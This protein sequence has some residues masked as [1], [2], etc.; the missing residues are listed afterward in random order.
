MNPDE[1]KIQDRDA[2]QAA[3][4]VA[5]KLARIRDELANE[6]A[7][8]RAKLDA[9]KSS[10]A[11]SFSAELYSRQAAIIDAKSAYIDKLQRELTAAKRIIGGKLSR[12]E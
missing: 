7:A 11:A 9:A 1:R 12:S 2:I 5:E 3:M 6:N 10:Q 8:L 4:A